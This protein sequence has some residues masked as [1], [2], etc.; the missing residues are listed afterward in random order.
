MCKTDIFAHGHN[1]MTENTH[2][3]ETIMGDFIAQNRSLPDDQFKEKLEDHQQNVH[4]ALFISFYWAMQGVAN[5]NLIGTPLFGMRYDYE[6]NN[7]EFKELE[8]DAPVPQKGFYEISA[9]DGAFACHARDIP[10][11]FEGDTGKG[12]T[13]TIGTYLKTIVPEE[14]YVMMSLSHQSLSDS[15]KAVF[16]RTEMEGGYPVTYLNWE[17]MRKT[18]A[19]FVDEFN[20]GNTN[21]LLQLSEAKVLTS[22]ERGK[23]GI[24][25]PLI[26]KD[27]VAYDDEEIKRLWL[28]GAQNPSK[29]K[30]AQFIG[31]EL[32]ASMKNRMLIIEYPGILD[33]VGSTMW[34][35]EKTND[36]HNQFLSQFREMYKNLSGIDLPLE[37]VKKDWLDIFAYSLDP[38][39]TEKAS[40]RTSI[41]LGDALLQILGGNL[42]KTYETDK[43]VINKWVENLPSGEL[44]NF[45]VSGEL[46]E[47]EEVKRIKKVTDS[48]DKPLTER[49][50]FYMKSLA[51][52]FSTIRSIKKACQ[53][54]NVLETYNRIP[55]YI[56]VE[57]IAAAGT[58][59]ARNKRSVNTG[60]DPL[61]VVN[62]VLKCYVSLMDGLANE[63]NLKDFDGKPYSR[64][65]VYDPSL[66]LRN[67][68]Y[69]VA[70]DK[71][72]NID[73]AIKRIN[74]DVGKLKNLTGGD[75]TKKVIVTRTI[76][77]L[78]TT[79]GFINEH[80]GKINKFYQSQNFGEDKYAVVRAF[81]KGLYDVEMKKPTF[82]SVYRHRLEK[83]L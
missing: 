16:E 75:D 4:S 46:A 72:D 78:A 44:S 12:K 41:D 13:L 49:D 6:T 57:D 64:F 8:G 14:N 60:T 79:V 43:R 30:D 2:T 23:A 21:D 18:A 37:A 20:L 82:S 28:T 42:K 38:K 50:D 55:A 71:S 22:R 59:L 11:L 66:G 83:V 65:D 35:I 33:S 45:T 10:L 68:I 76:A 48:F 26:T 67:V 81:I 15:P 52:L 54:D 69:T 27:G 73:D 77:D 25:I 39:M 17:N 51:D 1:K 29:S 34:F 63:M 70:L 24:K 36:L 61:K 9:L 19:M 32:P 47:T 3:L 80:K 58:L 53:S 31:V 56:T 74:R 40:I 62:N 5:T 7:L